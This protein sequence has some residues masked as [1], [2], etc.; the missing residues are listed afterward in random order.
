M[1]SLTG[2]T[3]LTVG[4]N[5][6]IWWGNFVFADGDLFAKFYPYMVIMFKTKKKHLY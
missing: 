4:E 2:A 1:P 6:Q 3:Q 5:A